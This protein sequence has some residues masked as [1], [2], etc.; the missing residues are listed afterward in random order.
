MKNNMVPGYVLQVM[1]FTMNF[2]NWY[3]DEVQS[4][5]WCRT[6]TTIHATINF[7]NCP[8]SG[9]RE[10]VTLALVHIMDDLK[11]DSFLARV[12]QNLTFTYLVEAGVPLDLIVQFCDN[13]AAQYKSHKPFI[14]L[15]CNRLDIIR[16][17][18][19]EKHGKSHADALFGRLKAWMSYRIK[20]RKYV[21]RNAHDFYNYCRES[22]QTPVLTDCCQ[23]YRVKFQFIRLSDISRHQDCDLDTHVDGTH[24]IYSVCNT[25]EPVTLMV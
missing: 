12:A 5:Y 8:R 16:I 22:Y 15:P 21:V 3:Q 6:Q 7:Y 19:G 20:S 1:D 11:H 14:E 9:C 10:L 23:H 2:N 17:Y 25:P 24:K 4:A 13:C 18:F